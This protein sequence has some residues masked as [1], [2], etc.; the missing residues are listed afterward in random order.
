MIWKMTNQK[1][2][3]LKKKVDY[4]FAFIYILLSPVYEQTHIQG[5]CDY[6]IHQ[7]T[8][9]KKVIDVSLF[10]SFDNGSI[11]NRGGVLYYRQRGPYL[12]SLYLRAMC[13]N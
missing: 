8:R 1:Y 2:T 12:V 6:S 10:H 4:R 9:I 13:F 3:K 11:V 5:V 7:H